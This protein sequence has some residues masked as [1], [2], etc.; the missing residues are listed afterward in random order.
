MDKEPLFFPRKFSKDHAM[1]RLGYYKLNERE[2]MD[3]AK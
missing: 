1:D 3:F 2:F